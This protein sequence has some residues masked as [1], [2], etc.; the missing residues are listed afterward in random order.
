MPLVVCA[1]L[2][3]LTPMFPSGAE[4][5]N[6]LRHGQSDPSAVTQLGSCASSGR[7]W[8]LWAA[9]HSQ[10]E[11]GPLSAQPLPRVLEL[12]ASKAADLTAFDHLG[13]PLSHADA[14]PN[15]NPCPNPNPNQVLRSPMPMLI[16]TLTLTLTLTLNQVLRS[17]M[18]M[19]PY[20]EGLQGVHV[21]NPARDYVPPEL[22]S[23]FITNIGGNHASYIYRLLSEYYHQEDYHIFN[24][25]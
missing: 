19:L 7:A 3:K 12:A 23:L 14:D 5:F 22:V 2:Y 20:E 9:R 8:R 18:P 6:V 21:P 25:E 4:Q 15:L 1:G 16:R 10:G 13:A 24:T 17:P 11:A